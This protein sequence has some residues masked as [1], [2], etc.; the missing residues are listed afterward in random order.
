MSVARVVP[1]CRYYRHILGEYVED[2][3][4]TTIIMNLPCQSPIDPPYALYKCWVVHM[5][6]GWYIGGL[7]I[8]LETGEGTRLIRASQFN[9][10][11]AV[12]LSSTIIW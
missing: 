2:I 9:A 1:A 8:R 4:Y 11:L 12:K 3:M 7:R 5:L 10:R 6:R